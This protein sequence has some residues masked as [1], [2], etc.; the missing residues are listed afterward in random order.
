MNTTFID[1]YT[2]TYK[3]LYLTATPKLSNPRANYIY[4][5]IF[6]RIPKFNQRALGYTD[7]KKHIVCLAFMY[8]SRPSIDWQKKCYKAKLKYFSARD[9]SLYQIEDD[10]YFFTVLD[11]CIKNMVVENGY[12]MLILVSRTIA[13]DTIKEFIESNYNDINVG[14]YHSKKSAAYKQDVLDNAKIIVSTNGSLGLG[15][16]IKDLQVVINAEAHRNFGDQA[17]GRLRRFDDG[18]TCFYCEFV[19]KGFASIKRQWDSRKKHY[20][21]I[22]QKVITIDASNR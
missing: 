9:H 10:S 19:D 15:E 12:R 6:K 20:A 18:R 16:T 1:C 11:E 8:N 4:Q 13:C 17:S 5:N 3:T 21:D 2:N 22:F 7:A 14:T